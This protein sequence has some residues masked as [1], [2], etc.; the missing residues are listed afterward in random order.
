MSD[1]FYL[2]PQGFP[3]S[4]DAGRHPA[5]GPDSVARFVHPIATPLSY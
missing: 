2:A 4:F 3:L 5:V 1:T